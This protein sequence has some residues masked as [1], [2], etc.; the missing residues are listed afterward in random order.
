M[1]G[2][3]PGPYAVP[4]MPRE[5]SSSEDG[6]TGWA[7]GH[8]ADPA[9]DGPAAEPELRAALQSGSAVARSDAL[10]RALPG[11]GVEGAVIE[12]LGDPA[13]EVRVAAVHALGRLGGPMGVRALLAVASTDPAPTVRVEALSALSRELRRR[14]EEDPSEP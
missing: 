11:P 13:V 12:A 3:P 5:R 2:R 8:L 4:T 10:R 7:R 9:S 6:P 14:A 1:A